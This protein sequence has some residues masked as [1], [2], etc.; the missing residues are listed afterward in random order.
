MNESIWAV[1]VLQLAYTYP[2]LFK[3]EGTLGS[4]LL[5]LSPKILSLLLTMRGT[6]FSF[7][8]SVL[9]CRTTTQFPV[10]QQGSFRYI[11]LEMDSE[12]KFLSFLNLPPPTLKNIIYHLI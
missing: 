1:G 12:G 4:I 7:S 3:N 5:P 2:L 9:R 10:R 11:S 8:F 6:S